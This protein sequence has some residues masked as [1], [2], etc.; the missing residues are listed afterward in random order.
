MKR[1][2]NKIEMKIEKT[3]NGF[4][5]YR[6]TFDVRGLSGWVFD[7]FFNT[8]EECEAYISALKKLR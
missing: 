2:K 5:L 4:K 8:A 3:D 1:Q 7:A 6:P